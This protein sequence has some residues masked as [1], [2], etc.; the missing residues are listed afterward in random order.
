M[1]SGAV[2]DRG[3]WQ[4]LV[5]FCERAD[6]WLLND[7]AMERILFDG[8]TVVHPASFDGVRRRVITVG[9]A[10]KEYRMID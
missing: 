2:L 6:C 7:A 1:P 5:E 4:A 9:S 10:S 8:R 3:E